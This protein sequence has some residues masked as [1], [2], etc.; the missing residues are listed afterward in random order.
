MRESHSSSVSKFDEGAVVSL[1]AWWR[2]ILARREREKTKKMIWHRDKCARELMETERTYVSGLGELVEVHAHFRISGC[3][4]R[5]H[6]PYSS[7]QA[8]LEQFKFN[9]QVSKDPLLTNDEINT[10]FSNVPQVLLTTII[11]KTKFQLHSRSLKSI[12]SYWLVLKKD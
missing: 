11:L 7:F 10:I 12:L 3:T 2:M 4:P 8:F 9:A 1:Q 5:V 6:H